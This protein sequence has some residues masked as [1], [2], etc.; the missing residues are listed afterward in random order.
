MNKIGFENTNI[1]LNFFH[2]DTYKPLIDHYRQTLPFQDSTVRQVLFFTRELIDFYVREFLPALFFDEYVD[3]DRTFKKLDDFKHTDIIFDFVIG[4]QYY[5]LYVGYQDIFI[6]YKQ[7]K[8]FSRTFTSTRLNFIKICTRILIK[9]MYNYIR[10]L[11]SKFKFA[12]FNNLTQLDLAIYELMQIMSKKTIKYKNEMLSNMSK[13]YNKILLDV[14]YNDLK[15]KK[16]NMFIKHM[17]SEKLLHIFDRIP[18]LSIANTLF[19]EYYLILWSMVKLND[20]K[21]LP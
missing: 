2:Y 11:N 16:E 18:I 5:F 3:I 15:L 9:S 21:G 12:L 20:K 10:Y 8:V 7:L 13:K 14:I 17:L 6:S 4:N 1:N 19:N